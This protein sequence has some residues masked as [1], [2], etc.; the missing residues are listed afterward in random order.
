MTRRSHFLAQLLFAITLFHVPLALHAQ[1]GPMLMPGTRVRV[2][3]PAVADTLLIGNVAVFRADTLTLSFGGRQPELIRIPVPSI[4]R[5]E[6]SIGKRDGLARLVGAGLGFGGGYLLARILAS[7]GSSGGGANIGLGFLPLLGIP[8]G[9][10][11]GAQVPPH[12]YREVP[13]RS[14]MTAH[15]ARCTHNVHSS[16]AVY[17]QLDWRRAF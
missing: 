16:S 7:S 10:L 9:A 1:S 6:V 17:D 15:K 4:E 3:A 2:A 12:R 13:L 8:A 5:L 14:C 11:L